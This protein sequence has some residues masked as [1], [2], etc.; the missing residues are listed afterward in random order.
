MDIV[1]ASQAL[2]LGVLGLLAGTL[3]GILP[4]LN[5]AVG[6]AVLLPFTFGLDPVVSL[7]FLGAVYT[8][9]VYGGAITA[10]LI[11]VPGAP[12]NIATC[13]DGHAMA[14]NGR[15][16]EAIYFATIAHATGG[17]IGVLSLLLLA[18]PLGKFALKFGPA[19][20]FWTY[21]FGFTIVASLSP[22]A[23][24]KG[25]LACLFGVL[26]STV[27][28]SPING[29]LRFDF[30]V[31]QLA[32]GFDIVPALIG[33]F[34][35][36]QAVLLLVGD[37][38]GW[39]V[40]YLRKRGLF[41]LVFRNLYARFYKLVLGSAIVGLLV[42]ILPGAGASVAGLLAYAN[43]KN[44]A[45]NRGE[46]GKGAPEGVVAPESANSACLGGDLIPT[47]S[48]GIPGSPA[49]GV[50]IGALLVHGLVPGPSLFVEHASIAYDFMYGIL[51]AQILLIP[52]GFWVARP[53]ARL[54]IIKPAYLGSAIVILS[55]F[56]GYAVANSLFG[57]LTMS[58][59]GLI[60][61][62]CRRLDVP[63]APLVLGLILGTGAE[64]SFMTSLE[65]GE[66][67]GS[68]F[69]FFFGRPIAV[70]LIALCVISLLTS[71]LIEYK[72]RK[73][74]AVSA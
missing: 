34:G 57:V 45:R 36:T 17:V 7:I 41:F 12:S 32:G 20:T 11:N 14:R 60:G 22:G 65:L 21:I 31:T 24:L 52:I 8:G 44:M 68:L 30:G 29:A 74:L 15:A 49:A 61:L 72:I 53:A 26:L 70:V 59:F 19:E 18:P 43:A 23:L 66:A 71:I 3:V 55:V 40:T 4:G 37:Q 62:L 10:I 56:G 67:T 51:L 38:K 9:G 46:F 48:L 47:L 50:M 27:G 6:I 35:F 2:I 42:G 58:F 13:F 33:L 64:T 39:Q 63:I 73:E 5:A 1:I 25:L 54:L 28:L 16:E 69:A